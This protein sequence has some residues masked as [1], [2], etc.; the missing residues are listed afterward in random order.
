M[1][2]IIIITLFILSISVSSYAAP[3][4]CITDDD[5]DVLGVGITGVLTLSFTNTSGSGE[6][7]GSLRCIRDD[8][9]DILKVNSDGSLN[10]TFNKP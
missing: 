6:S 8:N 2:K 10:I 9:E 5:G 4:R 7:R 3:V 1:I